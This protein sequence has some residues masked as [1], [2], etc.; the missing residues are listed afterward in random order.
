MHGV[1]QVVLDGQGDLAAVVTAQVGGPKAAPASATRATSQGQSGEWEWMMTLSTISRSMRG[2]T[3]WAAPPRTA[4]PR[5]TIMS[6]R[7]C[8]M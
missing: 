7:C 8:S 3:V 6:A 2:T 1:A 5:E 4:A